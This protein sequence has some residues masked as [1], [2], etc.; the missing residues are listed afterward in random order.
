MSNGARCEEIVSSVPW[1]V[2]VPRAKEPLT[3]KVFRADVCCEHDWD[4]VHD[5]SDG[6]PPLSE[7]SWECWMCGATCKR[8]EHG[9]IIEFEAGHA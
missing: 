5:T 7:Q 6:E 1:R 9:A 3:R 2:D 8:D 4:D